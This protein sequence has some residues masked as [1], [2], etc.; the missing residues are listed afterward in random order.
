MPRAA[1]PPSV[2]PS[3]P[4]LTA[5]G[6]AT[7]ARIIDAAARLMYEHGAANTSFEEV[8]KAAKASGSQMSHYFA[9]KRSLIRAVIAHQADAV[10]AD[11]HDA[12]IGN[13]DSVAAL[14]VWASQIVDQQRSQNFEGGCRLGALAAELVESDAELRADFAAG[15][16][17]WEALLRRGLLTMQQ[18][19][20]LG[21]D[22]NPD[23]LAR[24]LLAATQGG[25]LLTQAY[26]DATPLEDALGAAIDH[27]ESLVIEAGGA[28]S[29]G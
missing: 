25:Y 27:I 19:G 6:R 11:H 13:L 22:A 1:S 18:R 26:R 20:D 7:R 12:A 16:E 28:G 23:A 4:R 2:E 24:S 8:R 15:F 9:D 10:M 21:P 14:R 3:T 29:P 5:R 17:R